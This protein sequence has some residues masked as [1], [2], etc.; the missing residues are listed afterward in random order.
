MNGNFPY[1]GIN[2]LFLELL[3]CLLP[4]PLPRPR[5]DQLKVIL[6]SYFGV[7]HS[8]ASAM[9][10]CRKLLWSKLLRLS[11]ESPDTYR[12]GGWLECHTFVLSLNYLGIRNIAYGTT[13]QS[14]GILEYN[15]IV[16]IC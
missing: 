9:V 4:L 8:G 5:N 6:M 13:T 15:Y 10:P 7:A 3:L 12:G 11:N 16:Q 14:I 2:S 1:K